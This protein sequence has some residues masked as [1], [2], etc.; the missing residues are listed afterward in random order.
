MTKNLD[1]GTLAPPSQSW[2]C[3]CYL[4]TNLYLISIIKYQFIHIYSTYILHNYISHIVAGIVGITACLYDDITHLM[5]MMM[6][7][8]MICMIQDMYRSESW[9]YT[10]LLLCF[11]YCIVIRCAFL[12]DVSIHSILIQFDIYIFFF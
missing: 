12:K 7:M 5:M 6:M 8:M 4:I 3:Y 9:A 1:L 11:K 2:I 10:V